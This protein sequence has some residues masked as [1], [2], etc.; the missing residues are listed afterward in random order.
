MLQSNPTRSLAFCLALTALPFSASLS[1]G[2]KPPAKARSASQCSALAGLTLGADAIRLPSSGI[3]VLTADAVQAEGTR[4]EFCKVTGEILSRDRADPPIKFQ[5]NL[6]DRWN[7]KA[8]QYGGG[9]FNG[10][11]M[12]GL[13]QVV[14]TSPQAPLPIALGFATYGSDSGHTGQ[15][16]DG[17]FA[18]NRQAFANYVD[19][20]VQRTRDGAAALI[21]RYY[22][23]PARRVYFLGGSKG[24]QEAL[25][26]AQRY[27]T[28]FDGVISYFPAAQNQS[29]VSSWFNMWR[30][31]YS[32]PGAA[33]NT[34]KQVLLQQ[35]VMKA[36]DGL[37]G[38]GDGIIANTQACSAT[39]AVNDLRCPD[40]GDSGDMCLSDLQIDTL[41][42]AAK[43]F[44]FPFPLAN[45]ITTVAPF[46]VYLGASLNGLLFAP[47]GAPA[48]AAVFRQFADQVMPYFVV[49]K[50]TADVD[51]YN[52]R[53]HQARVQEIS[54]LYDATSTDL[55]AFRA[56]GGRLI[57]VQGTVDMLV[58]VAMT[59][60]Y[61]ERLKLRYG[62]GVGQTVR[63]YV[64]PGY[65]HGSGSFKLDW[66]AVET[67]DKWVETGRAPVTPVATD[68][69]AGNRNRT[70]PLCE[71]PRYPHFKGSGSMDEA[72][73]FTC[74]FP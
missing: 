65:G 5:L 17:R 6:P 27:P 21:R 7:G 28:D 46:P 41:E 31:A 10:V 19:E 26:A 11:V 24:G 39:F 53:D 73:N 51:N 29:L 13:D 74:K 40:G 69:N 16:F 55:D 32:R 25:I 63:Y 37:D 44:R 52:L 64:Q 62:A 60:E 47:P 71:Y 59:N 36:C 61:V 68:Q 66:N 4:P 58:P 38:A 18:L 14:G 57:I 15:G 50:A 67:L 34:A 72:R 70:M 48:K 43:P 54:R 33:L 49:G 1:A 12:T 3:Q 30:V 2:A 42:E 22:G 35:A 20:S 8:L 56:R 45:G 23:S 9:G